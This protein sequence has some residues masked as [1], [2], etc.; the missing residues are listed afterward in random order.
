[1]ILDSLSSDYLSPSLLRR[2]DADKAGLHD[3]IEAL[4]DKAEALR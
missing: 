3:K 1:M 2:K 4:C